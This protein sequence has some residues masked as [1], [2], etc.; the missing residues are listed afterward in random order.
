[1]AAG[2]LVVNFDYKGCE[3]GF[4]LGWTLMRRSSL[5]GM[6]RYLTLGIATAVL[7]TAFVVEGSRTGPGVALGVVLA[8]AQALPLALLDR[9]P[10][11]AFAVS[12]AANAAY[13]ALG[14]VASPVSFAPYLALGVLASRR[15]WVALWALGAAVGGV[16]L[17]G[18]LRPGASRSVEYLAN[19]AVVLG[20]FVAGRELGSWRQRHAQSV[21]RLRSVA[22]LEAAAAEG[23]RLGERLELSRELHDTLGHALAVI[24]LEARLATKV[25]ED[26]PQ[27]AREALEV[28]DRRA[29][30][31][32]GQVQALLGRLG[33]PA[34]PSARFAPSDLEDLVAEVGNA[35]VRVALVEEGHPR[36]LA[37]LVSHALYR[38]VQESLTNVLRHAGAMHAWV[39]VSWRNDGVCLRVSDDGIGGVVHPG[40]GLAGMTERIELLGGRLSIGDATQGGVM[41]EAD[42]PLASGA[43][44]R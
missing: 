37:P 30:E 9:S 26:D 15:R 20:C 25:M 8:L 12:E 19:V 16:V 32:L 42:L 23:A 14:Y 11:W 35:G 43:G 3:V 27:R 7:G 40:R 22:D 13:G 4:R 10:A 6:A 1:M 18:A 34:P 36:E 29:G 5:P 24:R 39:V 44:L 41:V 31:A 17:I 38:V 33:V 21:A 28:A 2:C